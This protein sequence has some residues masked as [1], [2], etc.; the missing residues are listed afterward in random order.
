MM[1]WVSAAWIARL[2]DEHFA[3]LS[4]FASQWT[5]AAEDCVQEAILELT[6]LPTP[7]ENVAGWLFHVVRKRAIGAYRSASRRRRHEA[8]AAR[9]IRVATDHRETAFD[10]EE[11]ALALDQLNDDE[12]EVVVA[13]TWGGLG[14]AEIALMLEISTATAFRRY[15]AGLKEL[16]VRLES[17]CD[18]TNPPNRRMK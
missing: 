10:A 6:R 5:D 18:K 17:R 4:L 11:L 16:R 7:P 1:N 12:R 13:R 2:L 15:E 3:A 8:L 14:F 9:L